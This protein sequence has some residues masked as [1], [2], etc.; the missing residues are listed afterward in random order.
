M[1]GEREH[2]ALFLSQ[3]KGHDDDDDDF[4]GLHVHNQLKACLYT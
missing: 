4:L 2:K 1:L 3:G